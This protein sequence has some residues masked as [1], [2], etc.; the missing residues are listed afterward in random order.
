ME[1]WYK[2]QTLYMLIGIVLLVLVGLMYIWNWY[3]KNK[4]RYDKYADVV[5]PEL[6][7]EEEV[8]KL[9]NGKTKVKKKSKIKEKFNNFLEKKGYAEKFKSYYTRA[10]IRNK[11]IKDFFFD[12]LKFL[13]LAVAIFFIFYYLLANILIALFIAV[14]IM[15]LPAISLYSKIKSREVSFRNDFPYFLQTVAFVLKNGTNFSQAFYEVVEK[16]EDTVLKE[17]M[18]DVLIIQNVNAGDYKVAFKSIVEKIRIDEVA[19]FVN[20]VIDNMEKGVSIADTFLNQAHNISKIL[21]LSI[22]KKI[23]AVSTKILVPILLMVVAIGV[24]FINLS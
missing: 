22:K 12:N 9:K 6:K 14:L 24:L 7:V 19:E 1:N 8:I 15:V 5:F 2:T 16:Q 3:K 4:T 11:S 23:A 20:V 21:N 10:G 18:Q 13:V 17:V